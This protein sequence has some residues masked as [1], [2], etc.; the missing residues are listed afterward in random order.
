MSIVNLLRPR[1][2]AVVGAT[3]R[4]GFSGS[5]CKNL[6]L[7][8][9]ADTTYFINPKRDQV[10][11]KA[12]FKSLE[13]IK[14]PI[15][16]TVIC[17][18]K[19]EVT[20]ILRQMANIG[21]HAAVLFASGYSETG[22]A[23]DKRDEEELLRLCKEFDISL[24]G[25][26][27]AGFVSYVAG[28]P[29]FGLDVEKIESHGKVGLIAQSGQICITMMQME[30]LDFSYVVSAGNS[31]VLTMED[32]L[33]FMVEDPDTGVIT[34]YM[35]GIT[36]PERFIE[37]L[38]KA[39]KKKKPVVVLK[40]GSSQKGMQIASSHTGSLAGS[41]KSFDAIFRKYGV[42]RVVDIQELITTALLLSTIKNLPD[43]PTFA[44]MNL[45]G[46]ETSVCADLA[47][48]CG[49]CVP[50][51]APETLSALKSFLPSYSTPNNPLD[52]T[53][54]LSY[55]PD[56]YAELVKTVMADDAIGMLLCGFT[57]MPYN[58]DPCIRLMAEGI[59]KAV[60]S[61]ITK[62]IA[63]VSFAEC[64]REKEII[65]IF[66]AMNIPV[67]PSTLYSFRALKY[68]TDYLEYD[69]ALRTVESAVPSGEAKGGEKA[70]LSEHSSKLLLEKAG[71]P[72][73]PSRLAAGKDELKACADYTG[74]PAVAKIC[75][76][77][78]LH[79]SDIG[80]VKLNLNSLEELEA[81]YDVIMK[82]ASEK[83]PDARIEG[84]L[85]QKMVKSGL[86]ILVGVTVDQQFGPMVMCGLGGV[87]VEIFKDVALYP[88]PLN[89]FEAKEM[90]SSL[91]SFKL[92]TGYRGGQTLDIDELVKTIVNISRFAAENKDT[93]VE[94]DIN[95]IFV[96]EEGVCAADALVIKRA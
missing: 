19:A 84:I 87:F 17:I 29:A 32:Y 72:T 46:G 11:G 1:S 74:F 16:L 91:K 79:K 96:Y 9:V 95:P 52:T 3:E 51:F 88:A 56:G 31:S 50:D 90:L 37:I 27:C 25:P 6:S 26:N 14:D 83:C 36:N 69:E 66:K 68:L 18:P 62:P 21:C 85:V 4:L 7:S 76:P 39:R 60:D 40:T 54:T 82:N 80:G 71:V 61:G 53:A 94:M 58:P 44:S 42:I 93:L 77:D 75:S 65:E 41:D 5:V 70:A 10:F 48:R 20:N 89:A 28:V 12:C 73:S 23:E 47:E 15:D 34:L 13:E 22:K 67:M 86:E 59:R 35:E 63:M 33:D 30:V 55:D 2:I 24:M 8:D 92:L 78:I 64:S 38:V 57:I 43:K 45:S 49:L 81:A